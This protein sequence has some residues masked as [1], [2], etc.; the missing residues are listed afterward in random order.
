MKLTRSDGS[1]GVQALRASTPLLWRPSQLISALGRQVRG[2][3]GRVMREITLMDPSKETEN[4]LRWWADVEGVAFKL[5]IPKRRVPKPWPLRVHVTVSEHPADRD[6]AIAAG[7]G[8]L[9]EPIVCVVRKVAEHTETVRYCPLGDPRA[10][11]LGEPY[12][13]LALLPANP[14]RLLH[15][16]VRWDR[17]AGTWEE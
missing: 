2:A 11:D 5:Y 15:L 12:I 1:W 9:E 4:K 10:W 6:K 8:N 13:P 16:E 17:S 7:A 14:P 3:W